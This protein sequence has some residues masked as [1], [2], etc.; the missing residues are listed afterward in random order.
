MSASKPAS[1][2]PPRW[3]TW[4]LQLFCP[5]HLA[6]EMEGDLYELFQ[7][8]IQAIGLREARRRYVMDVF[9]LL[10][11][12]LMRDK[13]TQYPNPSHTDMLQNYM[14]I[15]FRNLAKNRTYSGINIVGLSIGMTTAILI[16]LWMSDEL[17]YNKYHQHYDRIARPGNDILPAGD[18][19]RILSHA[20]LAATIH[21]SNS[22]ILVDFCSSHCR[23][24]YHHPR[25]SQFSGGEGCHFESGE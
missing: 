6:N 1:K 5:A 8:R 24:F 13:S 25:H 18:T 11:P 20:R 9:S 10:R 12:S 19:H 4:L 2:I 16:G 23:R 15:G 22:I 7:Q 14:K 17:S 21:L 3:A